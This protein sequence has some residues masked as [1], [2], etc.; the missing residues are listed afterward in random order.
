MKGTDGK[1]VNDTFGGLAQKQ[2]QTAAGKWSTITG[3]LET[4]Q[5][6]IGTGFLKGIEPTIDKIGGKIEKLLGNE[7]AQNKFVQFGQTV[8]NVFNGIL[9]IATTLG[10]GIK[11]VFDNIAQGFQVGMITEAIGPL[12]ES[13]TSFI[14]NI[15]VLAPV[16]AVIF[17][18]LGFVISGTISAIIQVINVVMQVLAIFAEV[19]RF[20]VEKGKS[21]IASFPQAWAQMKAAVVG[22]I[23]G[24]LQKFMGFVNKIIDGIN[25]AK[26]IVTRIC[27]NFERLGFTNRGVKNAQLYM[28]NETNP[29]AVLIES[30]FCDNRSDCSIAQNVGYQKIGEAIAT[31][32]VGGVI[33]REQPKP[34]EPSPKTTGP[35]KPAEPVKYDLVTYSN[36]VD[37]QAANMIQTDCGIPSM[38]VAN[39]E[40]VKDQYKSVIHVGGGQ[41]SKYSLLLQ[42]ANREVTRDLV[43]NFIKNYK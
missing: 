2:S 20:C 40:K 34:T 19:I 30:F 14:T 7:E 8:G 3:N 21:I 12:K 25:R 9:G 41:P 43:E 6:S 27:E 29:T 39:Y 38:S 11:W 23:N 5:S 15:Q 35:V 13:F 16:A 28:V 26:S 37:E 36:E 42:G 18:G 10:N 24:L 22:Y 1:T 31:G 17:Q 4:A 33:P 32:L